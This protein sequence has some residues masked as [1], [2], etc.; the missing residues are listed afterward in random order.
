MDI[1]I[2]FYLLGRDTPKPEGDPT[3]EFTLIT[4][5]FLIIVALIGL[6]RGK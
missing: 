1:L 6:S 2:L 3:L 4:I 5:V